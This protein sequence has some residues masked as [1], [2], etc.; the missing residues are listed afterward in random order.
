MNEDGT[1]GN[2]TLAGFTS[3]KAGLHYSKYEA[4]PGGYCLPR[5]SISCHSRNE[6]FNACPRRAKQSPIYGRQQGI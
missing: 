3:Y 1:G 4:G 5:H 6:G 2:M